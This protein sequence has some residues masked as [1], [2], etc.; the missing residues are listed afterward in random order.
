MIKKPVLKCISAF[1]VSHD[2]IVCRKNFIFLW[3]SDHVLYFLNPIFHVLLDSGYFLRVGIIAIRTLSGSKSYSAFPISVVILFFRLPIATCLY[4]YVQ[5]SIYIIG[6]V[7]FVGFF[8]LSTDFFLGWGW[9]WVHNDGN[10]RYAVYN[11][12]EMGQHIKEMGNM[13]GGNI[14][15]PCL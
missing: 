3:T 5:V 15:A 7:F 12:F 11:H 10:T 8:F 1:S 6:I 13:K 2:L 4:F 9:G 14:F